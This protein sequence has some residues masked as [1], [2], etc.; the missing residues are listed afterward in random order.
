[1]RNTLIVLLCIFM[2]SIGYTQSIDTNRLDIYFNT[3]ESNDKLMGSIAIFQ[4][5][6]II[7][8]KQIGFTDVATQIKP[9]I[10]TKY[11]IGSISKSFTAVLIF[12]AIEQD[13][14]ILSETIDKY[15]PTIKNAKK[16]TISDLLN[17]RSGIHSFTDNKK[18]YLSYRTQPKSEIE[19]VE[20]VSKYDSDFEP[21]TKGTYSNSNYLLLSYILEKVFNKPFA[22]ILKDEIC[23]P[24]KL[25]YTYFGELIS[26]DS[27]EAYSYRFDK[28]WQKEEQ[29]N[30]TAG[31]GAG[32]IVSTPTDLIKFA[33]AVFNGRII[34][35]RSLEQ[36]K[37]IRDNFGMGLFKT[38]YYDLVS[39][40]HN[41]GIDGFMS[42]LRYFPNE[43]MG[44][45]LTANAVD[46]NFN[47][48]ETI[49]AKSLLNKHF[50]IPIFSIYKPSSKE[51][52]KYL[53]VYSSETFPVKITVTKPKSHLV[54]II[55][56]QESIHLDAFR[57]GKFKFDPAGIVIEFITSK[58]EMWIKQ[59]GKVN[60]LKKE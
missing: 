32:S 2:I 41:G 50:D 23:T 26:I 37:T 36:M 44:F 14:I 33:D 42:M 21:N 34:S 10:N 3:L 11:R 1:M 52:K 15:Y 12:K 39:Y 20:I 25:E 35:K 19:M 47:S 17:H 16:I 57:K 24:L 8:N 54:L 56:N 13:N 4:E 46:Y 51:L 40:G 7:Y 55:A 48:I 6:E 59:G 58:N 43:K 45:A 9:D 38:P 27:N 30:G 53:G 31:M 28:N 22:Q 18:E 5:S 29:T 60:V 49:I